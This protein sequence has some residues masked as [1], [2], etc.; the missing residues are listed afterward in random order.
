MGRVQWGEQGMYL[1]FSKNKSFHSISVY[2]SCGPQSKAH[3]SPA[4]PCELQLKS[5]NLLKPAGHACCYLSTCVPSLLF[6]FQPLAFLICLLDVAYVFAVWIL[7][8]ASKAPSFHST[9]FPFYKTSV[10]AF[11]VLAQ[12][13]GVSF[14]TLRSPLWSVLPLDLYIVIS[15][16]FLLDVFLFCFENS[17]VCLYLWSLQ[18]VPSSSL[19]SFLPPFSLI[20]SFL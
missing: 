16:R 15:V 6:M 9:L 13:V 12:V 10:T 7:C 18:Q 5:N 19:L 14:N 8:H 11:W 2:S 17:G 20:Q 1:S 3:H 4:C